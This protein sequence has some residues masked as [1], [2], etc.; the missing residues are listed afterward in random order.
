M[1]RNAKSLL[2]LIFMAI[3]S[4]ATAQ[5]NTVLLCDGPINKF[6]RPAP[7]IALQETATGYL[8][9]MTDRLNQAAASYALV[10]G[11][12][13]FAPHANGYV[14]ELKGHK[15][16]SKKIL[17]LKVQ[18]LILLTNTAL[19]TSSSAAASQQHELTIGDEYAPSALHWASIYL[20]GTCQWNVGHFSKKLKLRE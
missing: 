3:S 1:L 13:E 11:Q 6:R 8:L 2:V 5:A 20:G 15:S 9:T 7:V 19:T 16:Y 14:L 4:S 17:T 10:S 18:D 12:V